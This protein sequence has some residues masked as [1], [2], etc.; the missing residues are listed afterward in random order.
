MKVS[1]VRKIDYWLG[2]P[3]CFLLTLVRYFSKL[4]PWQKKPAAL[5]KKFLF[6]ELSEM[7]SAILAYPAMKY[8]KKQYPGAEIFFM[9]FTKNRASVDILGLVKPANVLTINE[10]SLLSFFIDV[11]KNILR[12]WREQIDVAFDLELFARSSAILTYLSGAYK[13]IGFYKYYMEGLYRGDLLTHK[14]QYNFQQHIS[15]TF[16]SLVKVA[17]EPAKNY[18]TM[19]EKILDSEIEISS[20]VSSPQN[21]EQMWQKLKTINSNIA[22]N[23][24]LIVLNAGAGQIPIRA[25]PI[26]NYIELSKKILTDRNN[27]IIITGGKADSS[28]RQ[29]IYSA[30]DNPHCLDLINKTNFIE[31]I[32]LYNIADVL[33]TNDSGPAHFASLT[34]IKN[35]VFFGPETPVLYAPLGKNTTVFYSNFP[36]SPC[37]SAFNHRRTS[38]HDNKCLQAISVEEIYKL[39]KTALDEK[40]NK[41]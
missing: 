28:L 8:L 10:Q 13:R 18:P 31:L 2:A 9:I 26:A 24:N 37:L 39:I 33:I 29:E 14:V 22:S 35:F 38:C 3:I 21:K 5:A 17:T 30:L 20:V 15:K 16:L 4:K 27:F 11:F 7:G 1:V 6:I 19:S 25:W 34:P 36:C 23:N 12:I 40:N 32:D 41:K